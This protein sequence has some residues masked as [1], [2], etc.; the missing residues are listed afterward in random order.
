MRKGTSLERWRVNLE[1][2]RLVGSYIFHKLFILF[3]S[4][5]EREKSEHPFFFFF[6]TGDFVT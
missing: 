1:D 3:G 6:Q 5:L 2:I 4:S